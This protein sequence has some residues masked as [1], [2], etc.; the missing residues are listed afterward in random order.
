MLGWTIV[1]VHTTMASYPTT[2]NIIRP[3]I[4]AY[5]LHNLSMKELF[6]MITKGVTLGET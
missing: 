5:F 4:W 6:I 1:S 2:C 3:E